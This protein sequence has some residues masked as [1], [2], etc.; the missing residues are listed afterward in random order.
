MKN[1][2]IQRHYIKSLYLH[3]L[4]HHIKVYSLF[5]EEKRNTQRLHLY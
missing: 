3:I 1:H 4:Q 2:G 5:D